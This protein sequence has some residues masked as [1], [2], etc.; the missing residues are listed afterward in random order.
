M[1]FKNNL[2]TE[3]KVENSYD[4]RIINKLKNQNLDELPVIESQI[5]T[6]FFQST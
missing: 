5:T 6:N 1:G 2:N 3:Q 4:Q